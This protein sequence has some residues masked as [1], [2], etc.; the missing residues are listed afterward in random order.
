MVS[1]SSVVWS[2][3]RWFFILEYYCAINHDER[4]KSFRI[5]S[6]IYCLYCYDPILYNVSELHNSS[7]FTIV[8]YCTMFTIAQLYIVHKFN[9]I[10]FTV[11][12]SSLNHLNGASLQDNSHLRYTLYTSSVQDLHLPLRFLL[13]RQSLAYYQGNT[14]ELSISY[15]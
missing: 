7:M 2:Q 10:Q 8:Q 5:S 3:V 15:D 4:I 14:L 11:T 9:S 6:I 13:Q 1:T 12:Q